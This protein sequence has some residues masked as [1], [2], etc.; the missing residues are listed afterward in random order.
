MDAAMYNWVRND[1]VANKLPRHAQVLSAR[2]GK[3][4]V[5]LTDCA[6]SA[7]LPVACLCAAP[8]PLSSSR[9]NAQAPLLSYKHLLTKLSENKMKMQCVHNN[10]KQTTDV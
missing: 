7:H 4:T 1:S 6:C 9:S 3:I 8:D 2:L 5:T 10:V